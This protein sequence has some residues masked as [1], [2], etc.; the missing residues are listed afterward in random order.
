MFFQPPLKSV[1]LRVLHWIWESFFGLFILRVVEL[2]I[3]I[4]TIC[5]IG[6]I[7]TILKF[8]NSFFFL[9]F[10]FST[11]SSSVMLA[12]NFQKSFRP[13]Q[14]DFSYL[15]LSPWIPLKSNLCTDISW[16][17]FMRATCVGYWPG[18]YQVPGTHPSKTCRSGHLFLLRL[19]DKSSWQKLGY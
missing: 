11:S 4:N 1:L 17:I 18:H 10:S 9:F 6:S 5:Y 15:F 12:C 3:P 14:Q 2:K 8:N 13:I 16:D 7:N 19:T